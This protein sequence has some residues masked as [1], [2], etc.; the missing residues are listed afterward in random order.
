MKNSNSFLR[1]CAAALA[2]LVASFATPADAATRA[3]AIEGKAVVVKVVGNASY[4][5][6]KGG[7]GAI[8]EGMTLR[9]GTSIIT[10]SGASVTLDLGQNGD[11]LT[12]NENSTASLDTLLLQ[13]TGAEKAANTEVDAKRGSVSFN[14]KKLSAASKY[15]IK[16]ANGVAGIRGS[17]GV[18]Y[19]VGI[20][21][22]VD[23][24]MLV[25][26]R[27]LSTGAVQTFSV[28]RA[29]SLDAS[30]GA[31]A[32]PQLTPIPQATFDALEKKLVLDTKVVVPSPTRPT[33]P[34]TATG[35]DGRND[36]NRQFGNLI[37]RLSPTTP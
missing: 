13:D 34:T 33:S 15:E 17:R 36:L 21:Q 19:A 25:R 6:S 14:V 7:D 4:V 22:C 26:V 35:T 2:L 20:Y 37:N 16:T 9:Q 32:V 28:T 1:L 31:A 8:R 18:V 29:N 5:D 3:G 24:T 11:I 10:G 27:N 23:G 12:V 30:R